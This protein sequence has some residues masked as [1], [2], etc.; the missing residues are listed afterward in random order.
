MATTPRRA[1]RRPRAARPFAA[2]DT[3]PRT[4]PPGRGLAGSTCVCLCAE[5]GRGR[6]RR[7]AGSGPRHGRCRPISVGL[8]APAL[9]LGQR[10]GSSPERGLREPAG[11]KG[12]ERAE[13]ALSAAWARAPG[14]GP[15]VLPASR[16]RRPLCFPRLCAPGCSGGAPAGAAR[17]PRRQEGRPSAQGLGGP[18]SPAAGRAA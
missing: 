2:P 4:L 18:R 14:A 8:A 17:G 12:A 10:G 6:C 5:W 7:G 1:V 3:H 13:G 15:G 9:V 16:G 11:K